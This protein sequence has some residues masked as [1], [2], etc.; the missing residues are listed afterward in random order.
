[1]PNASSGEF[2]HQKHKRAN[3]SS[4]G[5]DVCAHYMR[6]MNT[7]CAWQALGD[8][9]PYSVM[10][11]N[12]S[13]KV[14]EEISVRPGPGCVR[15][16]N[17]LKRDLPGGLWAE[18]R[19]ALAASEPTPANLADSFQGGAVWTATLYSDPGQTT[20]MSTSTSSGT[21]AANRT[22]KDVVSSGRF[23]P[24][25]KALLLAYS[26]YYGCGRRNN[27]AQCGDLRCPR[28]W[29]NSG[30]LDSKT[31][32]CS[33]FNH[34]ASAK[35]SCGTGRWKGGSARSAGS[36]G[37]STS[38]EWVFGAMSG[39]DVEIHNGKP[40]Y[41][42]NPY[43]STVT[44]AKI[45]C[46]FEHLGNKNAAGNEF[47]PS[48]SFVLGFDYATAGNGNVRLPDVTTQHPTM[49]LC[50]RRR[51]QVWPVSAIRRVVHPYHLCP[52][53][54]NPVD[55]E[56]KALL[57]S[58]GEKLVCGVAPSSTGGGQVWK[59]R[60]KLSRPAPSELG[61][62]KYLLNEHHHSIFQDTFL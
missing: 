33:R 14:R 42:D 61:E 9:V 17:L 30:M 7:M 32:S 29:R 60:Y 57:S 23:R 46:F 38:D 10:W 50:G 44:M 52:S 12:R 3:K 11:Y 40:P 8:G 37:A 25:E 15:V 55:K 16:V 43:Y 2:A 54:L 48:T 31:V 62:D 36:S 19:D 56:G 4:S 47:T 27:P 21:R 24:D 22:W 51:P 49:R 18:P 5:R 6:Y 59:H 58:R 35:A 39:E 34:T 26:T 53:H 20:A 41:D 45:V 28:C 13:Q 1:M